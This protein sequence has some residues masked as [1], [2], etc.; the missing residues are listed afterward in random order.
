VF[1]PVPE[2]PE[3]VIPDCNGLFIWVVGAATTTVPREVGVTP[4]RAVTTGFVG[5]NGGIGGVG[6]FG[7]ETL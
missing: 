4:T 2:I 1:I 6:R 3:R 5:G 7:N